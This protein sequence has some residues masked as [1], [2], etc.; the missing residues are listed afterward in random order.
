MS[1][2]YAGLIGVIALAASAPALAGPD[3]QAIEQGRKAERARQQQG[4]AP[5]PKD[6]D[7]MRLVQPLDH[8]PRPQST[9]Y[10]NRLRQQR[11][12]AAVQ[13]C[14]EAQKARG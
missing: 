14:K 4:L 5:G 8:G 10:L 3:F 6:C 13:A 7:R 2:S 9:A 1:K 11:F 12:D